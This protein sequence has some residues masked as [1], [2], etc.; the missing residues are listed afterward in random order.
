MTLLAGDFKGTELV[1]VLYNSLGCVQF[2]WIRV[3]HQKCFPLVTVGNVLFR[4]LAINSKVS[5]RSILC[6]I[7]LPI[8]LELL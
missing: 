6:D 1:G 7:G 2:G 4:A 3:F 5:L 8:D